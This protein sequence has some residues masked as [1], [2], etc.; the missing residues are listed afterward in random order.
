LEANKADQERLEVINSKTSVSFIME[1]TGGFVE[2]WCFPYIYL[3]HLLK[4][5][6]TFIRSNIL[7][8]LFRKI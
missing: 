8:A 3:Y 6:V 1:Q 2:P 5:P 4:I 7:A